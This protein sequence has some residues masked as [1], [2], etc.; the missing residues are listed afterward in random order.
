[1]YRGVTSPDPTYDGMV[2]YILAFIELNLSIAIPCF[3][4]IKPLVDRLFPSLLGRKASSHSMNIE[5]SPI[6]L[7][8]T[9]HPPTISSAPTRRIVR[10]EDDV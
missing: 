5:G 4:T 1:M 9:G 7:Y 3:I 2:V 8:D 10:D 6:R